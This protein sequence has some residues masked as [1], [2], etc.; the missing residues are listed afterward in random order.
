[1]KNEQSRDTCNIGHK[2]QSEDKL[3]K[4][5]TQKTKTMNNMAT[6]TSRKPGFN[7]RPRKR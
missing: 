1:M 6:S 4:N 2:T 7:P 3:S 5:A